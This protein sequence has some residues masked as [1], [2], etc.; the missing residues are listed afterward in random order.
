MFK[1]IGRFI[2]V[3]FGF[4]VAITSGLIMLT[5]IAGRELGSRY[6]DTVGPDD[7]VIPMLDELLGVA[8]FVLA[9]GPALTV[10]PAL[11]AVI[12]GEVLRLRS[13]I[14]YMIAGG[15]AMIAIPLLYQ[16]GDGI[17]S[18]PNTRFMVIFLASGFVAGF[19]YWLIAGRRA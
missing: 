11:L 8:Q 2:V 15:A 1:S 10:L 7:L 18:V 17:S 4:C 6:S 9:L 3:A 19:I 14:Y 16:T 5:L 13:V 12:L